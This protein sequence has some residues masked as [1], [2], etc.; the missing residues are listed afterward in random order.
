MLDMHE[1]SASEN[2]QD[3]VFTVF[4]VATNVTMH[5]GPAFK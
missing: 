3:G 5:V 2:D 1:L 4:I